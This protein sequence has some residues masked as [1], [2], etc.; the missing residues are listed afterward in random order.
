MLAQDL[1][2]LRALYPTAWST[3]VA[4]AGVVQAFG[5]NDVE[6]AT[7]LSEMLGTTTVRTTAASHSVGAPRGFLG[8]ADCRDG[9][10]ISEHARP[11]LS[12]DEVRRLD[13]GTSLLLMPGSDPVR[14]AR[15]DY[16]RDREFA[17]L[18]DANPLE[19]HGGRDSGVGGR[20][21]G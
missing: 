5:T 6:T 20:D 15:L 21:W 14:A 9:W 3:F 17:G 8:R 10:T 12:P 18:F 19:E 4:N 1:A 13:P 11:L 2:Q 7:Y 16:R